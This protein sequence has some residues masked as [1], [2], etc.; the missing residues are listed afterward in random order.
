MSQAPEPDIAALKAITADGSQTRAK[1][2]SVTRRP[3]WREYWVETLIVALGL[4]AMNTIFLSDAFTQ[5]SIDRTAAGQLGDFVGGYVGTVFALISVLLL[6]VT[7]RNQRKDSERLHLENRS[8]S[9]RIHFE[10]K[11]FELIKLHR[12]NVAE[13]RVQTVVG[14]RLFVL[15]IRELRSI[16]DIVRAV[17]RECDQQLDQR[18]LL[19]VGYYCL[20]FGTGPNSSRMLKNS[21]ADYDLA[22]IDAVDREL[23]KPETKARVQSAKD[24]G[25]VP[26]EGH[27]SRLGHYYRHLYQMIRYVDRHNVD[28]AK[29]EYIKTIR[30]QLSTHEQALLLVN[31]LTPIGAV[32]WEHDLI[33]RYRLVQNL[34]R[35][36][37]DSATELDL[38]SLFSEGYFEWEEVAGV[39]NNQAAVSKMSPKLR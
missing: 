18:R 6:F 2:G 24:F 34:P 39:T 19:L 33:T 31:S 22:F 27:Q 32:W 15:F 17:A 11:Y 28:V 38:G 10:N 23:A 13:M 1:D 36:F 26:F 9:E 35:E 20:F 25:Y 16:L 4:V 12:D 29:Y 7:L 3:W 5:G 14:R 21:L 8:A 30:A 37:F